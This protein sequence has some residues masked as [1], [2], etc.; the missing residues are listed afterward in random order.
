MEK[1]DAACD[2]WPNVQSLEQSKSKFGQPK[3]QQLGLPSP[4]DGQ[5]CQ[6]KSVNSVA[7]E[8]SHGS[9]T[10]AVPIGC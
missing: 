6:M 2:M 7:T 3:H 5:I 1:Y 8:G 9:E 10:Q 4:D